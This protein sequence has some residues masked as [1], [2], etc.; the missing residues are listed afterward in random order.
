MK[1]KFRSFSEAREYVQKLEIKSQPGWQKYLKTGKLR[2][3]IPNWPD[4]FYKNKGWITWGDFLGTNNIATWQ[5]KYR[6]YDEVREFVQSLE[7]KNLFEWREYAKQ[8]K[9][10]LQ[11]K[12]IPANP[13]QVYK[14]EYK[15]SGDWLGTGNISSRDK[16]K[17][18]ISF[19]KAREFV[20]KLDFK[21]RKE[22]RAY[23]KSNKLPEKIPENPDK[24]YVKQWKSWGE[25]LGS[26]TIANQNRQFRSFEK[27]REYVQKLG[28]KSGK[29]WRKYI[30]SGNLPKDIPQNPGRTYKK[31]SKVWGIG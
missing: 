18:Y 26:G 22:F 23:V 9:K 29:Y 4:S 25:F 27:A 12:G 31:N 28:L 11:E 17:Q 20:Q 10:L 15:G 30:K 21:T 24:S 16:K 13:K 14:K 19:E 2:K 5:R 7:L 6:S 1:R 8:N 3:D